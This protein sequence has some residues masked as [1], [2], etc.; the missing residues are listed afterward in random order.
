MLHVNT[1]VM[2]AVNFYKISHIALF[3]FLTMEQA[4]SFSAVNSSRGFDSKS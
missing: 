3:F 1:F 4:V 2:S